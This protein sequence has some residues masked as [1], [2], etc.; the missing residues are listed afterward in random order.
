MARFLIEAVRKRKEVG[1]IAASGRHLAH[2]IT[3]TIGVGEQVDRVLEVGAGTGAFTGKI[4]DR[5]SSGGTADIVELNPEFCKVLRNQVVGPW[6]EQHNDRS[7]RVVEQGIEDAD[8]QQSYTTVVCGLPFNTFPPDVAER[9]LHQLVDLLAPG[10]TLA[11][12]EYAGFPSI[13]CLVP[14][15]WQRKAKAHR[16]FLEKLAEPMSHRRTFVLRNILPA[17]AVYLSATES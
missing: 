14:G 17:W 9:I 6:S 4:L 2:A 16:T 11:F 8:L 13:R 12:F 15:P 5:L 3:D 1:A 7:A 10:G